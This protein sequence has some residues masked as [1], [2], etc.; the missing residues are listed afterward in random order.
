[1]D[2]L[3]KSKTGIKG[4]DLITGGGLPA[5]R[6]SLVCGS[7]G[8]GKTLF[9]LNFIVNGIEQY[10]E[11]GVVITFE[12]RTEDMIANVVS[13]GWDL[14]KHIENKI[15]VIDY[16]YIERSEIEETGYY[17]L[18]GLFIRIAQAVKTTGAKRI[19]IDTLESLFSGFSNE[20]LLRA[21]IRRL[22]K[23]LKDKGLTSVITAEAG[24]NTMTRW[25]LEEY[26]SD[27]VIALQT[28]VVHNI[29]TRNLRL[30]KYRGSS[31]GTDEF[32]FL[33]TSTGFSVLPLTEV[34]LDYSTTTEMFSTGI[35]KIDEMLGSQGL[36][37]GSIILFT[38]TPG[39]G[40]TLLGGTILNAACERGEK[41]MYISFEESRPQLLRN[42][43]SI[44]IDFEKWMENDLFLFGN[45]RP[46]SV[47]IES[48]LIRMIDMMEDEKPSLVLIDPV[49]SLSGSNPAPESRSMVL[50][51]LH[52][53]QSMG[54]T[55]M[56]TEMVSGDG[57]EGS[58]LNITSM[59]DAWFRL[60]L[61]KSDG[62]WKKFFNIVK[63]RGLKHSGLEK[64]LVITGKGIDL[65]DLP[66]PA[67]PA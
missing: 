60:E 20:Q 16:V 25:G 22:F 44:G 10:D 66:G 40:K 43:H 64:E 56:L 26:L 53:M 15:L 13:L 59:V 30:V 47:G 36:Y 57:T 17:S 7:A 31:H 5:G 35:G 62:E 6:P 19:L 37:R 34:S 45:F 2:T 65:V 23:W 39:S 46:T 29:A 48:H 14:Q 21:E 11:P 18:D 12:E 42:F 28:K 51:I 52:Y 4:L 38:G 63:V 33:I 61:V 55:C 27:F 58:P 1:M 24:E 32:P 54:I 9:G 67:G 41:V 3:K 49:S 50:R 8:S